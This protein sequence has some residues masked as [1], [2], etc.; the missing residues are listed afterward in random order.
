[1]TDAEDKGQDVVVEES[2]AVAEEAIEPT[3]EQT[4][5]AEDVALKIAADA[6]AQPAPAPAQRSIVLLTDGHVVSIPP[7]QFTMN[8]L[9][10]RQALQMTLA[11]VDNEINARAAAASQPQGQVVVE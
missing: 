6:A 10:A 2:E 11:R 1:M 9:E 4:A 8:L 7:A 3:A 5:A